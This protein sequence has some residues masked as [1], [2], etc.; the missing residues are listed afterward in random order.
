MLPYTSSL[1]NLA[2]AYREINKY[3]AIS[4]EEMCIALRKEYIDE[5]NT[6]FFAKTENNLINS[7]LRF[8]YLDKAFNLSKK[9]Y[10]NIRKSYV[11]DPKTYLE[12]YILILMTVS[13]VYKQFDNY[14]GEAILLMEQC[15]SILNP[16]YEKNPKKWDILFYRANNNLAGIYMLYNDMGYSETI[17]IKN[18]EDIKKLFDEDSIRWVEYYT[19]ALMNLSPC[20]I[21]TDIDKS[22][23]LI[24]ESRE[25][26]VNFYRKNSTKWAELYTMSLNMLAQTYIIKNKPEVS[27]EYVT[28]SLSI[29]EMFFRKEPYFWS[30]KYYD[31]LKIKEVLYNHLTPGEVN[32]DIAE[33]LS[34]VLEKLYN[35]YG[36]KW[37]NKYI[38]VLNFLATYYT[39][40]A[41]YQEALLNKKERMNVLITLY[42]LSEKDWRDFYIENM[43]N[44]SELYKKTAI[45]DYETAYKLEIEAID[46][47][48]KLYKNNPDI[49][50]ERYFVA[51]NNNK[52]T[53]MNLNGKTDL[54][55]KV[56][57]KHL[58][59]MKKFYDKKPKVWKHTYLE[60][61]KESAILFD[62]NIGDRNQASIYAKQYFNLL[63]QK[64]SKK[65]KR[66]DPC[67]CYSGKKYKNCC[68]KN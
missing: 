17:Y 61:L 67:P 68:G 29:R 19:L 18:Y 21:E 51:L 3:E 15:I 41:N 9:S 1:N 10:I 50:Q 2:D 25:I 8:G 28:E 43:L 26:L 22:I 27:K 5:S 48:E 13:Q 46:I 56:V 24:N 44:L 12:E 34:K 31:I 6:V 35:I 36:E 11:S 63:E 4:L 47:L 42:T 54:L 20:Y 64:Q 40:E 62:K 32:I 45:A 49:W 52:V 30:E 66:N 65:I 23:K 57:L 53:L 7:Y 55:K 37:A 14:I 16:L 39:N 59:E 58:H 33:K 60:L 38:S